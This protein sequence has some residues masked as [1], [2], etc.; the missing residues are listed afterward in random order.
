[1]YETELTGVL[2]GDYMRELGRTAVNE[3]LDTVASAARA[4]WV[5]LAKANLTST[6]GRYVDGIQPVQALPSTPETQGR[7]I[8]LVG[9]L[10]LALENG[11]KAYDM[12]DTLLGPSVPVVDRGKGLKGK[13]RKKDGGFYRAIPF[14]HQTPGT[15]GLLGPAMGKAYEGMLGQKE[16]A[17]LGKR[18]YNEAIKLTRT[19]GMPGTKITWGTRLATGLAPKLKEHHA[20]DIYASMAKQSKFYEQVTQSSYVTF[21]TISTGSP[22]WFRKATPGLFLAKQ[23][24]DFIERDVIRQTFEDML[25]ELTK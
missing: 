17:A 1:M 16:A 8:Q 3:L 5:K 2:P 24:Q 22:G 9:Q 20:T 23:V 6:Q 14:R 4:K 12:H 13:H 10:P 25:E 15:D 21:R 18:I 19:T 11:Q 7:V